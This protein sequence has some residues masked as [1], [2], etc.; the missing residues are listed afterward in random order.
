ME[1]AKGT[2]NFKNFIF[3]FHIWCFEIL[4][5]LN[6]FKKVCRIPILLQQ[7]S[8]LSSLCGSVQIY[9]YVYIH[10]FLLYCILECMI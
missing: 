2:K 1:H 5:R 10:V 9:N 3:I 8:F 4:L 7:H 6:Y